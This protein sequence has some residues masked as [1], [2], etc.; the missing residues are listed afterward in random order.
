MIPQRWAVT[1][2]FLLTLQT[3][4]Y[5]DSLRGSTMAKRNVPCLE[6]SSAIP[7]FN[8]AGGSNGRGGAKCLKRGDT[9]RHY[10]SNKGANE[11]G[12]TLA[13][14]TTTTYLRVHFQEI[15]PSSTFLLPRLHALQATHTARVNVFIS[16]HVRHCNNPSRNVTPY[17]VNADTKHEFNG[18]ENA[19]VSSS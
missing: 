19:T 15:Q 3:I 5:L 13:L 8:V 16:I 2:N 6:P 14:G 11:E 7:W 12:V 4:I 9:H 10:F 18:N 17:H 1:S